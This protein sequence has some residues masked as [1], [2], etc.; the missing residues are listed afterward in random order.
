M[1]EPVSRSLLPPSWAVP[2]VFRRRLGE[3]SGRQRI[4]E[5][6]GHLLLVLHAPPSPDVQ[7]R[8][9]R[10]FWRDANG[11]WTPAGTAPSQPGV[12]QLLTQYE[13]TIEKLQQAEDDAVT[14]RQYFE[15][16]NWLN[17]L[18]RSARNL[19]EALQAG[20]EAVPDDRQLLLWRDRAYAIS[21]SADL[22]HNDAKNALDFAVAERAEQE[23][24]S[25]RRGLTA[26][27][28]LNILVACFFPIATMAAVFGVNLR[29]G[30]EG[31]DKQY[32]PYP[33]IAIL[34]GGLLLG[35]VLTTFINRKP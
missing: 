4:M 31:Y 7:T 25:S 30:L 15:L 17:P 28:R 26:A 34:S 18:V 22:L 33:L 24:E 29:H 9:G 5:H 19:H 2:D 16:L 10:F 3:Q 23:A 27:H 13:K 11:A 14:A 8:E 6:E 32:A 21:R 1:P 35:L 12:G 20:R